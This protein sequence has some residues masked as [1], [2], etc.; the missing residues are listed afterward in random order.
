MQGNTLKLVSD[1]PFAS[2]FTPGKVWYVLWNLKSILN[3]KCIDVLSV[4][5]HECVAHAQD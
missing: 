2:R 5:V 4:A 3:K 1:V